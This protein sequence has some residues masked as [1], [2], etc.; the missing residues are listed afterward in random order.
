MAGRQSLIVHRGARRVPK[1]LGKSA[2][3]S[4][5]AVLYRVSIAPQSTGAGIMAKRKKAPA[6]GAKPVALY[7]RVSTTGQTTAN[8]L[9]RKIRRHHPL[10]RR[11]GQGRKH[12]N[13][14]MV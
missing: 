10:S 2:I 7:V 11:Y 6:A 4:F 5:F 9:E 13:R 12:R 1:T 3:G 14:D 8:Q